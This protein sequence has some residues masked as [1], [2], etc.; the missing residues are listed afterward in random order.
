M[1]VVP[2]EA[3]VVL[4]IY[5]DHAAGKAQQAIVRELN[6]EGIRPMK[7]RRWSQPTVSIILREPY[8]AGRIEVE[9][10]L[11]EG[12]HEAIVS[13]ELWEE[14]AAIRAAGRRAPSARGGRRPNGSH[15]FTNG[16]LRCGRCGGPMVPRSRPGERDSY[17]CLTRRNDTAACAQ[18]SVRREVIDT[19]V[20]DYFTE[21]GLSAEET[22]RQ[23]AEQLTAQADR[24]EAQRQDAE[25]EVRKAE[26]DLA[27]VRSDYLEG[28]L[29]AADWAEFRPELTEGLEAARAQLERL[30]SQETR[31]T[32]DAEAE[33][34]DYLAAIRAAVVGRVAERAGVEAVRETL[35]RLFEAFTLYAL[36]DAPDNDAQ[37]F[38]VDQAAGRAVTDGRSRYVLRPTVRP[39]AIA[40]HTGFA[41]VAERV[42]LGYA[43]GDSIA[44]Q[45]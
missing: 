16:T 26:A 43:T 3:E 38:E 33:L 11:V 32:V 39:E 23:I 22:K 10:E 19:A 20:L 34:L 13:A 9:G 15:L 40:H 8:Y 45:M 7:A 21:V 5:R 29:D 25:R 1:V 28:R 18:S 35:G 31:L 36:R 17:R 44:T 42:A 2:A 41:P 37:P 6:R 12:Q 4:R 30:A 14:V 27:R 24:T